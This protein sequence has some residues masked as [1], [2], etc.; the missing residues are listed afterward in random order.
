MKHASF[1]QLAK[2]L[3][4]TTGRTKGV[5]ITFGGS[6]YF[7]DGKRI[8]LPALAPGTVLTPQQERVL[9]GGVDHE[10]AHVRWTD[11]ATWNRAVKDKRPMHGV[12][13]YLLN[14]L[15]DIRI[16]NK[17]IAEYPGVQPYLDDLARHV[18]EKAR[19]AAMKNKEE[20]S[21]LSLLYYHVY[22]NH[23][24]V[25]T[26]IYDKGMEDF[27]KWDKIRQLVDVRLPKC[28]TTAEVDRLALDVLDLI[29]PE[30]KQKMEQKAKE[31][32]AAMAAALANGQAIPEPG[33]GQ[34][35]D[36]H[37][38]RHVMF[39]EVTGNIKDDNAKLEGKSGDPLGDPQK[40]KGSRGTNHRGSNYFP[41]A[42]LSNDRV[43]EPSR[44]NLAAYE[45][46]RASLSHE[47]TAAKKMLNLFLRSR[48]QR[49]WSRGLEV[50]KLDTGRLTQLLVAKDKRVMKQKR[51]KEKINTAIE[52]VIDLSGSMSATL[53]RAAAILTTEALD[54]IK[55]VEMEIVGFRSN[56][57][58]AEGYGYGYNS[59]GS[60]APTAGVGRTCGMDLLIYKGYNQDYKHAKATLGGLDTDG[61]TPL[62]DA[63]GY[64]LERILTRKEPRRTLWI[65][66]DGDACCSHGD[67]DHSDYVLMERL[68][69]KAARLGVDVVG[70]YIGGQ[71]SSLKNYVHKMAYV[72]QASD[73]PQALMDMVRSQFE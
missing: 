35:F 11:F 10:T 39:A 44:E 27:P 24:G 72:Q 12:R 23:R 50:G 55:G 52:V 45:A 34:P 36:G 73:L 64:G 69:A 70:M 15:E 68:K 3:A 6:D 16:E 8:N 28:E 59:Y 30:E 43:F 29:P 56:S 13:M 31:A 60:R 25:D 48:A 9:I 53:T 41:P 19:G 21:M 18:D 57:K 46:T 49:A 58:F 67:R 38:A 40:G 54:G 17:H 7:T 5:H 33:P 61:G 47:I 1:I 22:K 71:Q 65:I 62:G 51:D 14:V 20:P 66:S 2:N 32:A 42:S 37:E 63:Y 26:F 4:E